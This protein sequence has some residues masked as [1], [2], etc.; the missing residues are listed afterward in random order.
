MSNQ[1]P[2]VA[3]SLLLVSGFLSGCASTSSDDGAQNQG[4]WPVCSLIG[5]LIGGGLGAIE[6]SAWAAGGAATGAI[7][8]GLI[9]FAQDGDA[10]GDGVFDRRDS[11]PDTP[12]GSPV[13][14]RGCPVRTYPQAPA[15]TPPAAE[16]EVIV[17]SDLGNVLFAFASAELTDAAKDQL[18]SVANRLSGAT[19][20]GVKVIGH[21]D[22][23]GSEQYNQG[24][25]ERRARSVA[26]FL[27]SQG[28]PADK[29]TTEGMG[30]RQPVADNATEAGRA[31]NR[32]VEI[33]VDR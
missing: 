27:V 4:I 11:C 21:T 17:L 5:G 8:G 33:H 19:L 31:Q 3:I 1:L 28:V 9:C 12:A 6:S 22:S 26:D 16:D 7:V 20:I 23:V 2:R 13:D 18:A 15:E 32:R 30:E 25:S 29:L 14:S 10:D 24:L